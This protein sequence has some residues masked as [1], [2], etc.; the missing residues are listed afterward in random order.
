[1]ELPRFRVPKEED[2]G[3]SASESKSGLVLELAEEFLQRYRDGQRPSLQE[4]IDRHPELAAEIREVFPAMAMMENI[5]LADESLARPLSSPEPVLAPVPLEQ[6]GD[7]RIIRKVGQGGMGIVYEAEQIS[8]GRHVALK[9]LPGHNLLDKRLLGRFQREARAA[10]RLHHTNIVPV[11]SVGEQDGLH[12]LVMQFIAGL[13]LDDVLTELGRFHRSRTVPH[14]TTDRRE[15]GPEGV[16]AV[17]LAKALRTGTCLQESEPR[18]EPEK[19]DV[20]GESP[21]ELSSSVHLPGQSSGSSLAES[22][23]AY[24]QSVARIGL[25]VADALAYAHGQGVLHRDIKPSNLLLDTAATV[26]ITDF[27]L[28]KALD[29]QD[30]LTQTGDIV[31]TLRYMAPERFEGYG[32]ARSDVYSLGLTLYELATLRPAF[33]ETQKKKLIHQILH[34]EPPRPRKINPAI[35]RDLET[36]VLKASARHPTHRYQTASEVAEDLTRFVEDRPIRARR[37]S[38]MERLWRWCRRNPV[39]AGLVAAF[40]WAL[41][42]GIAGTTLKW[43]EAENQRQV[44][45][46]EKRE[47]DQARTDAEDARHAS[48]LQSAELLLDRGQALAERG[49]VGQGLHWML[50]SLRKMP[51]DAIDLRRVVRTNLAAWDGQLIS[52]ERV[53]PHPAR[54]GAVAFSPDGRRLVTCC[55]DGRLRLWDARTGQLLR[56]PIHHPGLADSVAFSPDGKTVATCS[57]NIDPNRADAAPVVR[58]WDA[59][60]GH[61][62]GKPLVHPVEIWSVSF[63]P[64][65]KILATGSGTNN[66][67]HGEARFWNVATGKLIGSP[68]PHNHP[69]STVCFSPDGKSFVTATRSIPSQSNGMIQLW[70]AV[71]HVRLWQTVQQKGFLNGQAR[72]SPDGGSIWVQDM[73]QVL[74][75]DARTGK[76]IGQPLQHPGIVEYLDPSPDG[77]TLAA[78]CGDGTV[79]LW[80]VATGQPVGTPLRHDEHV[81]AVA[82]NPD[83]RWLVSG[84]SDRTARLW[85]LGSV[86]PTPLAEDRGEGR[87]AGRGVV[88]NHVTYSPDR[89]RALT[90]GGSYA[91]PNINQAWLWDTLPDHSQGAVL[92]HQDVIR[93]IA[94]SADGKRVATGSH[95]STARI[96]DAATGRPLSPPLR[97][98]NY[99][100]AVAFSPDGKLLAAG[101][102]GPQGLVILWDAATGKEVRRLQDDDIVLCV[103]FSPDGRK[104]AAGTAHDWI[105]DPKVV[106]W[107]LATGQPIGQPMRH[108]ST[109][110]F[111]AF[112]PDGQR[113]LSASVD[114]AV[115]LWDAATCQPKS[116][117]LPLTL[118]FRAA[119]FS[120]DGRT[121][122]TGSGDGTVRLYDAET[123]QPLPGKSLV[124][125]RPVSAAAYSPDSKMVVVGCVDGSARL[126]DVATGRPLGPPCRQI[127]RIIGVAF[128]PEG[129]SFLSTAEDGRTRIWPAPVPITEDLDRLT[130]HVQVRTGRQLDTGQAVTQLNATTWQEWRRQFLAGQDGDVA[131]LAPPMGEV[132]WHDDRAR[133]AEQAG[134][135]TAALWHLDR[136]IAW[137]SQQ[138]TAELGP[139]LWFLHARR[140]RIYRDTGRQFVADVAYGQALKQGSR[141][142]LVDWYRHRAAEYEA[143][144]LEGTALWYLDRALSLVD[145]DADLFAS[146]AALYGKSGKWEASLTD[147]N[148]ALKLRPEE[149]EWYGERA[150][151]YARLAKPAERTA[152]LYNALRHGASFVTLERLAEDEARAGHW[153]AVANLFAKA[154]EFGPIPLYYWQL[155][156][157]AHRKAGDETAYRRLCARLLEINRDRPLEREFIRRIAWIVSRGPDA[158][159]DWTMPLSLADRLIQAGGRPALEQIAAAVYYRAGRYAD[160]LQHLPP[161]RMDAR[162]VVPRIFLAMA[163]YRLGHSKEARQELA[164]AMVQPVRPVN[165]DI[166]D[167]VEIEL[168]R[169]EAEALLGN[170]GK[171]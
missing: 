57:N 89:S 52:L 25:Q 29:D 35:P 136:L 144:G 14:G 168:L 71:S 27:G 141:G 86:A 130:R 164:R 82:F 98:A 38:E 12:Y 10:A 91:T 41:I 107:D 46:R 140:G 115:R 139:E 113:L 106:V 83:G 22:G 5:A 148:A 63:S 157:L 60:T 153:S 155:W 137:P 78:A 39:V 42:S 51:D 121:F 127:R 129:R 24:W 170:P 133:D 165:R 104:L 85:Q 72:F 2:D 79:R 103:A 4:Y 100:A 53:M 97:H 19:S 77:R 62:V 11:Y 26:W 7:F 124:Q 99:V 120:P 55:Y 88:F 16:S 118:G 111:L 17:L 64:D 119:A 56:E 75:L 159:T 6:L 40:L 160:A 73:D 116:P 49:D 131:P 147:W 59:G 87:P 112:S 44:A 145:T 21:S 142:L 156:A 123:G 32:D 110:H 150:D 80:D 138:G 1:L 31:G 28:A 125:P 126:W 162:D 30:D 23:R 163:H 169:R 76:P 122:L 108:R 96:W 149:P 81:G 117:P 128:L 69:V 20:A 34:D 66:V 93:T 47:A 152:D 105:H 18:P 65:G 33:D 3:M 135:A 70:D 166:W 9:V 102:Y 95:D 171:K 36:I 8:L 143:A 43:R 13:G 50:E 134:D 58:L 15:N 146:R 109:V 158:V 45:E 90:G 101:D 167:E 68:L 67:E 161:D 54:I 151:V 114:N 92:R 132:A 154:R 37:I 94:F 48:E 84:G 61:P 74:H